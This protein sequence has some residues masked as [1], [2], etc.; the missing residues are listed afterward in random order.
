MKKD[1]ILVIENT[2]NVL[3]ELRDILTLEGF[4]LITAQNGEE[5]ILKA[6]Q[7]IPDLILCDIMMPGKDGYEVFYELH[8]T[9]ETNYIP[10]ST[11]YHGTYQARNDIRC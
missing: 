7:V 2:L 4:E 10:Y 6:K 1:K 11:S 3:E 5:G 8:K 9:P